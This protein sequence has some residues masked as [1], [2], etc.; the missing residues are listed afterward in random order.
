MPKR[1]SIHGYGDIWAFK[2]MP[3]KAAGCSAIELS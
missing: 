1:I 3:R 2:S